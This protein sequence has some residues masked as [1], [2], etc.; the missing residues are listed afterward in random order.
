MAKKSFYELIRTAKE[1]REVDDVYTKGL[2]TYFID[3][4][5][6]HPFKCDSYLETKTEKGKNLWLLVEYKYDE[7]FK[8]QT[9]VCKVLVQVLFYIKRFEDTGKPLPNVVLVGDKDECFVLQTNILLPYLDSEDVDWNI[10]PSD[11]PSQCTQLLLRLVNDESIKPFVHEIDNRFSF[12][13]IHESIINAADNV[14]RLVRVTEHNI[15]N[16]YEWFC[17]RVLKDPKKIQPSE[18]VAIF[19]GTIVDKENYY[20]HPRNPNHLVTPNGTIDI[21]ASTF[22]AFISYFAQDYTPRERHKFSEISDRLIEDTKRRRDG[23]FYTPTPFVDYAHRM[24]ENELG[25]DWR[26]EYVVWDCC[27]GTGNLTR[28]YRF[29]E[30]YAST[31][32]RSELTIGA[33][34]NREAQKF[35][36]DFLNDD[37]NDTTGLHVPEGLY[38][39]LLNNKPILF[40]INPPYARNS[41]DNN[42]G[43][44]DEVCFTKVRHLMNDQNMG[45][46]VSN[47]YAQF[48]YRII[49]IREEFHLSNVNIGFFS[50]TLYLSG[51]SWKRFRKYFLQRFRFTNACTFKASYFADVSDTWGISFSVW[52]H[53]ET[54]TTD[55]FEHKT[56]DVI[57]GRIEETGTINIYN[58]DEQKTASIWLREET[59]SLKTIEYIELTS[60]IKVRQKEGSRQGRIVKNALGYFYNKSNNVDKNTMGIALFSA[61]FSDNVGTSIIPSNYHKC[62]SLFSARKLISKNWI[63]SKDEYLAPNEQHPRWKEFVGDSLVYS[64]FHSSSNQ[65]S[66]RNVE[67]KG[68]TW[69]IYNEFFFMSHEEIML[70]AETNKLYD[71]YEE[72]RTDKERF[73]F[74]LLELVCGRGKAQFETSLPEQT[75]NALPETLS[76]EALAVLEKA[77][78]ITRQTFPFRQLFDD[79]HPEYQILNW[80]CGWYQIKALA[81]EYKK[82]ELAEFDTIYKALADKMRPM[83]YEIGFLK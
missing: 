78:E 7:N 81:K 25:E 51:E 82:K 54:T 55:N 75:C 79:E 36:F 1:E 47:L 26:D 64:L 9:G 37:I 58:I 66:L 32:Y 48:L 73:V 42:V 18:L 16:I 30:L 49:M 63:N 23:E 15:A 31:K 39:A 67:Y 13:T 3:V 83:V 38:N 68:K 69:N 19:I 40:F 71:T 29:N 43:T 74:Q 50:P 24:L 45:V 70:L 61:A 59:K 72:A 80:D 8:T 53:G 14:Q 20:P 10:A 2:N 33:P 76:K 21:V 56:I 28:D 65:S 44:S 17:N 52:K 34:Y 5:I 6:T 11:A 41:G 62:T 12:K 4:P 35:V 22:N 60:A 46:C 57:E 77:R 27:W